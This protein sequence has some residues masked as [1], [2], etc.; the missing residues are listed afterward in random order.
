MSAAT[1]TSCCDGNR[2]IVPLAIEWV[3]KTQRKHVTHWE[4]TRLL[5]GLFIF[6]GQ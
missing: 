6:L 5:L 2:T 4:I 3:F 1:L